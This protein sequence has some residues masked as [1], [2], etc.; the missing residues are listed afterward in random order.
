MSIDS[1]TFEGTDSPDA[2]EHIDRTAYATL[3]RLATNPIKQYAKYE[4]YVESL[5]ER[6]VKLTNLL[7]PK[8][9]GLVQDTDPSLLPK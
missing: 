8:T 7:S 1:E 3:Q 4:R 5:R 2:S 6:H 9:L